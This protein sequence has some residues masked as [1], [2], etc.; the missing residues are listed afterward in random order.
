M[1]IEHVYDSELRQ[2]FNSRNFARKVLTLKLIDEV[3]VP[4]VEEKEEA[5][6]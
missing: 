4:E 1:G 6:E 2:A 5:K 3:D